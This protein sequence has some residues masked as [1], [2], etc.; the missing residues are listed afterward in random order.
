MVGEFAIMNL[1]QV[2]KYNWHIVRLAYTCKVEL[3]SYRMVLRLACET[4]EQL[5]FPQKLSVVEMSMLRCLSW[6]IKKDKFS[7]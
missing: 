3:K 2:E 5:T 4:I 7:N 1:G 6:Q